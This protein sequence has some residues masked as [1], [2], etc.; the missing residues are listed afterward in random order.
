MVIL[1]RQCTGRSVK[2]TEIRLTLHFV[3][4]FLT[5]STTAT[6]FVDKWSGSSEEV[7]RSAARYILTAIL[8]CHYLSIS[9]PLVV[10]N[11]G[12]CFMV[13]VQGLSKPVDNVG[14]LHSP[15]RFA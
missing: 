7:F 8:D 5:L 9:C 13:P 1:C 11:H 15:P 4:N 10:A 2:Y 14:L 12:M 3:E 6:Y